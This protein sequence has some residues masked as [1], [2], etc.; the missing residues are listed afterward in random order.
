MLQS[1]GD[2]YWW[3]CK[4]LTKMFRTCGMCLHVDWHGTNICEK[5]ANFILAIGH[6][7]L[8][9]YLEDKDREILQNVYTA[10]QTKIMKSRSTPQ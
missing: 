4:C 6:V 1:S 7:V 3:L 5:H 9:D 10:S 8:L 2:P